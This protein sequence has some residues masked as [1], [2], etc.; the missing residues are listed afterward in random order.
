MWNLGSLAN[1][2][3]TQGENYKKLKNYKTAA[4]QGERSVLGVFFAS[5]LPP[6]HTWTTQGP[7][8]IPVKRKVLA[9]PAPVALALLHLC[10]G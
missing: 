4:T 8:T 7:A 1:L 2:S 9:W 10:N 5:L 3:L 6:Q